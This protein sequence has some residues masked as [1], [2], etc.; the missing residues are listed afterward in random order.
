M[1]ASDSPQSLAAEGFE[2]LLP[3]NT[4]WEPVHLIACAEGGKISGGVVGRCRDEVD[5]RQ[6]ETA[7]KFA[8]EEASDPAVEIAKGMNRE[9]SAFGERECLQQEGGAERWERRTARS[10]A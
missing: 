6:I 10:S 5:G 3:D 4:Q 9:K 2:A 1:A 7:E 8:E